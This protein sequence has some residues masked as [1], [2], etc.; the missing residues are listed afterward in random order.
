VMAGLKE[1]LKCVQT[2]H[3]KLPGDMARRMKSQREGI[4]CH[5]VVCEV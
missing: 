2:F 4:M 5:I 3:D 1:R